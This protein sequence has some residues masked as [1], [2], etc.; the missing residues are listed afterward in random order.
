[1]TLMTTW[2]CRQLPEVITDQ[3]VSAAQVG[4]PYHLLC[5]GQGKKEE[6]NS[7][8][9][10]MANSTD[11]LTTVKDNATIC[12][13]I[14]YKDSKTL[15]IAVYSFVFAVG[16]P[17][18]C[19][20]SLLTFMQIQR[21][22][23]VAIYIFSLSLC[24]LMYLSTLPL[25]IIYVQNEHKW[26]MG[27]QICKITGF[28]FF[29]NIYISILLLCCISVDRY[30]AL[31]YA[32]ESRGRRE[33]KKAII[34][35][36][37]LVAAVT[38]IHSPVFNMKSIHNDTCFETLPLDKTLASFGFARFLFG[39]AIPF[40]ILIF[41]NYKI[42]QSTKTSTSLTCHQ[43]AKVKYLAI[44]I[45]VIFLICFSPYHVVLLIRS[46]YFLLHT[47]CSCPF[48]KDIYPVFT[49]FLCLST[50]NSVADPIIYVLVSE[51][52]RK[53][54]LRSLRRWR[55]NSSRFNSSVSHKTESARLKTSKELQEGVQ[56][57]ENKEI[58][59]SS[60]VEKTCH[61]SKDPEGGS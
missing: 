27:E 1:M 46:V 4:V 36:C 29:C 44:A 25:W 56:R 7:W 41:T 3:P 10:I 30:V 17:A 54:V 13:D 47:D 9:E 37:F 24:E 32:L 33:R 34:I 14:S 53:D 12:T 35:V 39:F 45:I 11:C 23:V 57:E 51:N 61:T 42:F 60:H 8:R 38:I 58:A 49:V 55:S 48:E 19:I 5:N 15:L 20:T 6:K 50:A 28:I 59:N 16:L 22:K 21:N 2:C 26:Y 52:V 18:N 43:K 40:M 31:V